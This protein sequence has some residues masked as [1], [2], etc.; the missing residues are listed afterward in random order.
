MTTSSTACSASALSAPQGMTSAGTTLL[1]ADTGNNRVTVYSISSVSSGMSASQVL[2]QS[3]LASCTSGGNNTGL[4][5]PKALANNGTTLYVADSGNNRVT[6]YSLSSA[7]STNGASLLNVFGQPGVSSSTSGL[8]AAAMNNPTGVALG[9]GSQLYVMDAGNNR[10][11][12]WNSLPSSNG[13]AADA[14]FGQQSS[15][16]FS[17]NTVNDGGI[18]VATLSTSAGGLSAQVCVEPTSGLLMIA[19]QGNSRVVITAF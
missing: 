13:Q 7:I 18:Q 12:K 19:D 8:S 10:L 15:S 4:T 14:V 17:S 16:N 2:G 11:L 6:S 3:V 5:S 1:V 9:S